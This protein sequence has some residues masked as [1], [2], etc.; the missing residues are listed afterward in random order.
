[1][2][3]IPVAQ[4]LLAAGVVDALKLAIVPTPAGP[5]RRLLDGMSAQRLDLVH[6]S[7]W[8]T[9]KLLVDTAPFASRLFSGRAGSIGIVSG[10]AWPSS[11]AEPG[12]RDGW[13][14]GRVR[15]MST[16]V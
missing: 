2:H 14:T 3:A 5:G 12:E 9:G 4:A 15:V 10:I 8:P 13:T 11:V 16:V 6:S 7:T 1:M